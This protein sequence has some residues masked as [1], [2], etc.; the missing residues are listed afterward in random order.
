MLYRQ[1]GAGDGF[2]DLRFGGKENCMVQTIRQA[3]LSWTG[4]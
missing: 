2:C 4:I 1:D 3:S